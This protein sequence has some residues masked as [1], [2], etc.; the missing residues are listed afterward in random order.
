MRTFDGNT[1]VYGI[2][3][4]PVAHS[5]SPA[6]HNR[7]FDELGLNKVYVPFPVEDVEPALNGFRALNVRGVS[8]TIPHKQAVIPF[9]DTI[10]PVA[11]RIGA[12][13]TLVINDGR[14]H[15][16][17]TDWQG[18]N[19]ALAEVI[20]PAGAKVVLLG[21]GGSARALG[22]GLLEAGAEIVIVSR[23]PDRGRT[24]AADLNCDWLPLTEVEN[25]TADILV[26]ATSVGMAPEVDKMAVPKA[27]LSGYRVVMDIVYAPLETRLLR[28]AAFAG[29]RVINGLAMLLYQGAA[30]FELW[31]GRKPPI[32]VM[33]Q[34]LAQRFNR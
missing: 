12:V 8:V 2:M 33:R 26:N 5:L 11:A 27:I 23:T 22:F 31:T 3:G 20:E 9:L 4:W 18:A 34:E 15:G 10:E 13:N 30:Q 32:E 19:Q 28:E 14:I 6:I 25:L 1:E 16:C 7:A 17:N 21:A 24:L 29:C